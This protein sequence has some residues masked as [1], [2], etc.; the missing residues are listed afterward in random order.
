M[1][2]CGA[3]LGPA[4]AAGLAAKGARVALLS[5]VADAVESRNIGVDFT[6]RTAVQEA[7]AIAARD[8]GLADLIVHAAAPSAALAPTPLAQMSEADFKAACDCALKATLYTFQAGYGQMA[9]RGGSMVVVGP[10][11]SLV[12]AKHFVPLS[13]AC[14][15]QRSLV[16]SAA[17]QWG[18]HGITVNWVG[19]ANSEFAPSLAGQGPAVPELGPPPCALG[20]PPDPERDIASVIAFIGSSAGRSITGA[21]INLDGGDWMLP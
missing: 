10:A 4:L 18:R 1:V 21:T 19:A 6:S 13:T 11:L 5:D 20:R 17:R 14:E 8:T 15:S 12:G 3:P 7:F 2:T 16:K 9:G